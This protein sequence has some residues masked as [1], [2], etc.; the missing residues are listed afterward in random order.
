M[1]NILWF[2]GGIILGGMLGYCWRLIFSGRGILHIDTHSA[3]KDLYNF[4]LFTPLK[5]LPSKK[6]ML[7]RVDSNAD[8][9]PRK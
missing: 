1:S 5:N 7:L 3:E 2:V 9:N 6:W 8:L 4:E